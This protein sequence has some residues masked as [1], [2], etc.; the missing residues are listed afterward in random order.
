MR[1]E[2]VT[3]ALSLTAPLTHHSLS[4]AVKALLEADR[5][6]A[7]SVESSSLIK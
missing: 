6:E 3:E 1:G 4:V 7:V 5:P 2:T